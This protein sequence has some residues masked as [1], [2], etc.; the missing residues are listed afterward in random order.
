M[1]GLVYFNEHD[2]I[3]EIDIPLAH[4]DA[5]YVRSHYDTY[6]ISLNDA[7]KQDEI[8]IVFAFFNLLINLKTARY[9]AINNHLVMNLNQ[10]P[11]EY[12]L[13]SAK[14]DISNVQAHL[15]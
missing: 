11:Q 2:I 13:L 6:T 10:H 5:I 7:P 12:Y 15:G 9:N 8:F 1:A 14:M 4:K 3:T